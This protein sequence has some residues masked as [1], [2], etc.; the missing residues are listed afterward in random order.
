MTGEA[1]RPETAMPRERGEEDD[2]EVVG[3]SLALHRK[4]GRG[5]W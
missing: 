2:V 4:E 5:E 1:T 3:S